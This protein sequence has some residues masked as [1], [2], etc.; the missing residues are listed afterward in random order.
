MNGYRP[1]QSNVSS[2]SSCCCCS[3]FSRPILSALQL[4]VCM[5]RARAV[6]VQIRQKPVVGVLQS[7][8]VHLGLTDVVS[9]GLTPTVSTMYSLRVFVMARITITET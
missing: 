8:A 5:R 4:V 9:T 2:S 1:F 6:W 7:V 3:R